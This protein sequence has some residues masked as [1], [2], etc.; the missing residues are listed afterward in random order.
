MGWFKFKPIVQSD[1]VYNDEQEW[2]KKLSPDD[3]RY[4]HDLVHWRNVAY[5]S[6]DDVEYNRIC[7]EIDRLWQLANES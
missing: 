6:N 4:F 2:L 1:S 5:H 7:D 3:R